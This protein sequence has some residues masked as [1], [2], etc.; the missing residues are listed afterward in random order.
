VIGGSFVGEYLLT[1]KSLSVGVVECGSSWGILG[2]GYVHLNR[3]LFPWGKLYFVLDQNEKLFGRGT[4]PLLR[5]IQER[6]EG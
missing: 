6:V 3:F 5:H 1:M 2:I 4:H